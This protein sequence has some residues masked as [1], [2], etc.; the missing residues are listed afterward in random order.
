VK[1]AEC[2]GNDV[3]D[4][5]TRSFQMAVIRHGT[6]PSIMSGQGAS[7]SLLPEGTPTLLRCVPKSCTKAI[8]W[9]NKLKAYAGR[10]RRS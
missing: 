6:P 1:V 9:H 3:P 5:T 4:G 10:A 8:A 7:S 2:W